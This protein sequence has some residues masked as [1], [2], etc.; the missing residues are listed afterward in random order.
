MTVH[1]TQEWPH[2]TPPPHTTTVLRHIFWDHPAPGWASVRKLLEFMVQG[3]IN[4]G[5]HI[6]QPTGRHSTRT[7]QCPPPPSPHP[8]QAGCPSCRPTNSVKALK[9]TQSTEGTWCWWPHLTLRW[10]FLPLLSFKCCCGRQ[11]KWCL[12]DRRNLK[13][14]GKIISRTRHQGFEFIAINV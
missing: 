12:L 1:L 9:A 8:L 4:R 13:C 3:K 10:E 6:D 7:N 14:Y 2:L 11:Q 5:R